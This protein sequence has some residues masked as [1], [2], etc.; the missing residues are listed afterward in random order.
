MFTEIF[1]KF[2]DKAP[3]SII[4]RSTLERA[5]NPDFINKIYEDH[6]E[7]QYTRKLIFFDNI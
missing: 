7:V 1:N 5:I 2:S 6:V 3:I 4:F